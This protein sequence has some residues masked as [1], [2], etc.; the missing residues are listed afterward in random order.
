MLQRRLADEAAERDASKLALQRVVRTVDFYR[1]RLTALAT[2]SA[3]GA[4]VASTNIQ[5][6]REIVQAIEAEVK[7]V[8]SS[9]QALLELQSGSSP[10]Q[11]YDVLRQSLEEAQRRC[12]SLNCD[13]VHQ[14]EANEE[15]V[16]A[17]GTVKDANKRLLEQI[18][19]QTDEI[20]ALTQQRIGDEERMDRLTRKHQAEHEAFRQNLQR[21]V[22]SLKTQAGEE[23]SA[24]SRRLADKLRYLR[25]RIE[26][27]SQ[28]AGRF[29]QEQQRLRMD[30]STMVDAMQAQLRSAERDIAARCSDQAE[31]FAKKQQFSE[32]AITELEKKLTEERDL[33]HNE[34]LSWA[35]RHST[36]LA[37]REDV[38]ARTSRDVSEFSSQLQATERNLA[39]EQHS[40]AAERPRLE[41]LYEESV[42]KRDKLQKDSDQSQRELVRLETARGAVAADIHAKEQSVAEFRRQIRESDDALAAAVSGN[43]HLREQMEEQRRRAQEKNEVELNEAKALFEQKLNDEHLVRDADVSTA[44]RQLQDMDEALEKDEEA[45]QSLRAQSNVVTAELESTSRDVQMYRSQTD[46]AKASRSVIEKEFK[47]ARQHFSGEKLKLQAAIDRLSSHTASTEDEIKRT[48]EHIDEFRRFATSR[49]TEQVTRTGAA[50]ALVRECQEDLANLKKH[51]L[52]TV[53]NRNRADSEVASVRQRAQELLAALEQDYDNKRRSAVE[54]RQR[55]SDQ[56]AIELRATEQAKDQLDREKESSLVMLRKVQEESRA[57]LTNAER[58]RIRVEECCHTDC[59]KAGESV[60]QQQ[61]YTDALE[62]DLHRLRYL[63]TESE[64]NLGW[65][66]QELDR[67]E[68]E[69]AQSLRQLEKESSANALE[70]EKAVQ[71]ENDLIRQVEETNQ[72]SQQEQSRLLKELEAIRQAALA[73]Q[74]ESE[75]K[76]SRARADLELDMRVTDERQR[77]F[78]VEKFQEEALEREN[79]QLKSFLAEQ[80]ATAGGLSQLHNKLESHIQRLQRHTEDLRRDI[81][82]SGATAPPAL[83]STATGSRGFPT[84][85]QTTELLHRS[86][87][88]RTP[89]SEVRVLSPTQAILHEGESELRL[90]LRAQIGPQDTTA[91]PKLVGSSFAIHGS[92]QGDVS[93]FGTTF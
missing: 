15:L 84:H 5:R 18:R 24:C 73:E 32:E 78:N 31:V 26:I 75:A 88:R 8:P 25:T 74:A 14:A 53:D 55:L 35:S 48:W 2:N 61:K 57:K 30:V 45:L 70:L 22:V 17:L 11:G 87:S 54:E 37:E 83:T 28:D 60:A 6:V 42:Q 69:S 46:N 38:Q 7:A 66:R 79:S 71:S 76:L 4:E 33:R 82:S 47:E 77:G 52:E 80:N 12:E 3:S 27:I 59:S 44:G 21:D 36:L 10:R 92:R 63:L 20:A 49:E 89:H 51:H 40:A 41:R 43:E 91:S 86:P 39:A 19:F 58:E 90:E 65:V 1:Q 34:G 23:Y 93:G 13:M 9:E 56:L 62:H 16:E 68:R 67:E 85:G 81:H 29:H 50:E 64:A 72:R